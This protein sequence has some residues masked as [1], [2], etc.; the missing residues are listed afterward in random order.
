MKSLKRG[1][2]ELDRSTLQPGQLQ[3]GYRS[4][5]SGL[6]CRIALE[7]VEGSDRPIHFQFAVCSQRRLLVFTFLGA[8]WKEGNC[9]CQE[10][11]CLKQGLLLRLRCVRPGSAL[12]SL[13]LPF[14]GRN[15]DGGDLTQPRE[16]GPL[17]IC[18]FYCK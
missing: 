10:E 13:L 8:V 17:C 15:V 16:K 4:D 7:E 6:L 12:L 9:A 11:H 2:N 5:S 3:D 1:W 18:S 14:R